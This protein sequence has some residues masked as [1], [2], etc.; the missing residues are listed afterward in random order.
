MDLATYTK[1]LP[2]GEKQKLAARLGVAP[3]Y[4]SRLISGQRGITAERAIQIE[5]VTGGAVSRRDLCPDFPWQE[6]S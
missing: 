2:R 5:R 6:A 3:T 1:S 4:L